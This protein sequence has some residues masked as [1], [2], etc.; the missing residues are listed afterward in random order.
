MRPRAGLAVRRRASHAALRRCACPTA[1]RA[2]PRR[3][4]MNRPGTAFENGSGRALLVPANRSPPSAASVAFSAP[5]TGP[6]RQP[7]RPRFS[8][9]RNF[10]SEAPRVR[11]N[12][13]RNGTRAQRPRHTVTAKPRQ[14]AGSPPASGYDGDGPAQEPEAGSVPSPD[15]SKATPTRQH[16]CPN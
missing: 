2:L 5:P 9:R 8:G 6:G 4:T 15:S 11:R 10:P 16:S 14:D 3:C 7:A 12:A 1:Y 13:D